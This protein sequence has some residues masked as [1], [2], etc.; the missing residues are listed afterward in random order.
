MQEEFSLQFENPPLRRSNS[1][2]KKA[3]I[4]LGRSPQVPYIQSLRTCLKR[5][6]SQRLYQRRN[7]S[8]QEHAADNSEQVRRQSIQKSL[9]DSTRKKQRTGGTMDPGSSAEKG[10]HS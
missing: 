10:T 9:N 4:D 7:F 1:L 2:E 6:S 5:N 3:I 8:P